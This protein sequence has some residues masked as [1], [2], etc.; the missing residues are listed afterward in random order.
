MSRS[1]R[2]ETIVFSFL[3]RFSR[4]NFTHASFSLFLLLPQTTGAGSYD[5]NTSKRASFA[6][7]LDLAEA[8]EY[9]IDKASSLVPLPS[10]FFL[11]VPF[12][13]LTLRPF[14][15]PSGPRLRLRHLGRR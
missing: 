1:S 8:Q 13:S 12:P 10:S 11:S 3:R 7:E 14:S 4:S 9:T 15:E 6:Q 2:C 5:S